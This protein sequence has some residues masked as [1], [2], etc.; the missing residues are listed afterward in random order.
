MSSCMSWQMSSWQTCIRRRSPSVL[1]SFNV[2]HRHSL[3][4]QDEALL[5]QMKCVRAWQTGLIKVSARCTAV[6]PAFSASLEPGTL[7]GRTTSAFC[8]IPTAPPLMTLAF[9]SSREILTRLCIGGAEFSCVKHLKWFMNRESSAAQITAGR[10]SFAVQIEVANWPYVIHKWDAVSLFTRPSFCFTN[11]LW[12]VLTKW[13]SSRSRNQFFFWILRTLSYH[14]N[15]WPAIG[16]S[17]LLVQID[18]RQSDDKL[19]WIGLLPG[20]IR[21]ID[22]FF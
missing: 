16:I 14:Y 11:S 8:D 19:Q 10:R 1:Q 18:C 22:T 17:K 3:C 5:N 7:P 2:Q 12:Q 4:R 9:L 15:N 21:V 13:S 20:N 6:Q